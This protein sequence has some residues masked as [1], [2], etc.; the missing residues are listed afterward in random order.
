MSSL[1]VNIQDIHEAAKRITGYPKIT[2]L[3]ESPMLNR[4][5]GMRVFLKDECSQPTGSFKVR[6]AYNQILQ[7]TP[8]ERKQEI[9]A[10]SSGNHAQAVAFAAEQLKVKA[11]ILMPHDAPSI[12]ANNTNSL[13]KN[14]RFI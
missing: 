10:F 8:E 6:G 9:I 14:A 12:K 2:P 13:L 5:L 11:T 1:P 4:A 7:L 3:L